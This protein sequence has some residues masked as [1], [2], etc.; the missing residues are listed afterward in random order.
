MVQAKHERKRWLS[1]FELLLPL[2]YAPTTTRESHKLTALQKPLPEFD[3]A[4]DFIF[5]H[6]HF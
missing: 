5:E 1:C 4:H 2:A 6:L 3:T